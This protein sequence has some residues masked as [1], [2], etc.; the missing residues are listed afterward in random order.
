MSY[1]CVYES[2][3]F[4]NPA[5]KHSVIRVRTRDKTVPDKARK[6]ANGR[7]DFIRFIAKGYNLPQ[8]DKISMILEGEWQTG[9]YGT[10][11]SVEDC[12]EIVP[13][14]D[15]G[16]KGYLSSCLVKG[17]GEKT[18]DDIIKRF[19][20]DTLNII[21]NSPEKLLEIKGISEQKLEDIKRT[22]NESYIYDYRIAASH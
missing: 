5:D 6:A 8:T 14:T 10:Q 2:T 19:G 1:S 11:L 18:A 22:F 7:D 9:K 15:E 12:E 13:Y 4:Y 20:A 16:L 3:L 17:I 21:E